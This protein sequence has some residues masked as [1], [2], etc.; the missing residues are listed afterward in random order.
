M[1]MRR[2]DRRATDRV[3]GSSARPTSRASSEHDDH[4]HHRGSEAVVVVAAVRHPRPAVL[5]GNQGYSPGVKPGIYLRS[6]QGRRRPL[7]R[8][9]HTTSPM[10]ADAL[11]GGDATV[12]NDPAP[13]TCCSSVTIARTTQVVTADTDITRLRSGFVDFGVFNPPVVPGPMVVTS[14]SFGEDIDS[15]GPPSPYQHEI[16]TTTEAAC[17]PDLLRQVLLKGAGKSSLL[18]HLPE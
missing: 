12:T 8:S 1:R 2:K 17:T 18:Q 7:P 13:G 10:A 5:Q 4:R 6:P 3:T 11:P 9:C 15:D 16:Y 14:I